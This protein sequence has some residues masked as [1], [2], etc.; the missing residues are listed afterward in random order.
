MDIISEYI[1]D[2][3][4]RVIRKTNNA[5]VDWHNHDDLTALEE[6]L[7]EDDVSFHLIDELIL[8]LQSQNNIL[9]ES[10]PSETKQVLAE[11]KGKSVVKLKSNVDMAQLS[12]EVQNITAGKKFEQFLTKNCQIRRQ[13]VKGT[14]A[15]DKKTAFYDVT[16][17]KIYYAAK[18]SIGENLRKVLDGTMNKTT[19]G[20][21][22]SQ[23]VLQSG[24]NYS[25][26][27]NSM[28]SFKEV[29]EFIKDEGLKITANK[30]G[31]ITGKWELS[32]DGK[33][34]ELIIGT[35]NIL[36]GHQ[37]YNRFK[38]IGWKLNDKPRGKLITEPVWTELASSPK[39]FILPLEDVKIKDI[40]DELAQDIIKKSF[41]TSDQLISSLEKILSTWKNK[42]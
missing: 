35:T 31:I 37:I 8:N 9:K 17:G 36:S 32:K 27:L 22:I 18:W 4:K 41:K 6:V 20:S 12:V 29:D 23:T 15:D 11:G 33:N 5:F 7:S 2:L 10:N 26:K 16:D 19:V 28:K 40:K 34:L 38:E 39:I 24:G 13:D 42:E 21:F 14:N 3:A 1:D 30:F 25:Q